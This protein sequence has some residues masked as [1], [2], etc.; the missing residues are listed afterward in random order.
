M[1]PWH[2]ALLV[3]PLALIVLFGFTYACMRL[4]KHYLPEGRLKRLLLFSWKV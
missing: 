1:E 2:V 3:K 4:A